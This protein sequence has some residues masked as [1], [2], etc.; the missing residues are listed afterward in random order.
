[1]GHQTSIPRTQKLS[2]PKTGHGVTI[3]VEQNMTSHVTIN[4]KQRQVHATF[5]TSL[6]EKEDTTWSN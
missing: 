4:G 2:Q 5:A 3:N 6:S 1:M